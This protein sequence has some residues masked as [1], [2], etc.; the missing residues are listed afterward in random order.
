MILKLPDFISNTG[1]VSSEGTT[2][3]DGTHFDSESAKLL[4]QR[5][6]EEMLKYV[7]TPN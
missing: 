1:V 3:F 6:A 7:S 4:G 5:Y 2:V